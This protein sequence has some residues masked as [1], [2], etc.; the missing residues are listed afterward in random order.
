MHTYMHSFSH[1]HTRRH[2]HTHTTHTRIHTRSQL[3]LGAR[4]PADTN[5]LVEVSSADVAAGVVAIE[6]V[7]GAAHTLVMVRSW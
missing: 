4:L 7:R 6:E 5:A 1:T 3:E 2:T